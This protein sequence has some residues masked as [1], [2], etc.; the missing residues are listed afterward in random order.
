MHRHFTEIIWWR[1]MLAMVI[2]EGLSAAEQRLWDAFPTGRLVEFGTGTEEDADPARGK[3]WGPDRQ[4]RAEVLAALLC[5]AVEVELGQIGEVYLDGACIVGK[6]EL[7]GPAFKYDLRLRECYMGDGIDLSDATI[8][9][10]RLESCHIGAISLLRTKVSG[11]FSLR[12]AVVDGEDGMALNAAEL[13]VTG[14]VLCDDGFQAFGEINLA[15]AKIRGQFNLRGAVLDSRDGVA[16]NA[17]GLTVTGYVLCNEG[18]KAVGQVNLSGA[19]FGDFASFTGATFGDSASFDETAFGDSASF[20]GA[21]FGD[22]AS[23]D[24]TA[25][26][27][28]ASFTNAKFGDYASF[29]EARF[30]AGAS[31]G[32]ADFGAGAS[33]KETAFNG[34]ASFASAKFGGSASFTN[35]KFGDY[36]H[37]TNAKF[38]D[39]TAF[40]G[41][42]FGDY[43]AFSTVF[44]NNAYFDGAEFG[45]DTS[46]NETTFGDGASFNETT[47]GDRVRFVRTFFGDRTSFDETTFGNNVS[48]TGVNFGNDASFNETTFGDGASLY[49]TTLGDR[50]LFVRTFFGDRALFFETAFGKEAILGA[51]GSDL[52]TLTRLQMG[53]GSSIEATCSRLYM[54]AAAFPD[55]V[56]MLVRKADVWIHLSNFGGA[57]VIA[58][59]RPFEPIIPDFI[60]PR[61]PLPR[62]LSLEFCDVTH[63]TVNSLDLRACR[64]AGTY[65]LEQLRIGGATVF[66]PQPSARWWTRRLVLAEEHAWRAIYEPG[67]RSLG[68]YPNECREREEP[69]P[70]RRPRERRSPAARTEAETVEVTYR[71]LRKGLEDVKNEPGAADF[72]YGEMEMR[73]HAASPRSVERALLFLYWLVAGY[74]LRASRA[75]AALLLV[76]TLATV[77][78]VVVGFAPSVT[79]VYQ[80]VTVPSG[81]RYQ[82]REIRGAPPG[83]SE[84]ATYSVQSTTSLLRTPTN[85]P[86]TASGQVIDIVLRLLGPVLFGLAILAVRGRVKR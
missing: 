9:T 2:A 74:G 72:Y 26:G 23:F 57:S 85:E 61:L 76:L 67:R 35:A 17:A 75:L 12:G 11:A 50:V 14:P 3:G 62:L 69:A 1:M 78:F 52:I 4:V 41:A 25:F 13:N 83:W 19:K 46:F 54:S 6:L 70:G 30:G 73:R 39:Y 68:W 36:A 66:A 27:D 64:F 56:S 34:H 31:F 33:F 48:F 16:L 77:G 28:S 51:I 10:L 8:Q 29:N 37:F 40:I 60:G 65:N 59:L 21:T 63:V 42:E 38:G 18:F 5:G 20:T 86:L 15:G 49:K 58:V 81:I 84:A 43:A 53:R 22:S 79:T 7:S 47:L 80:Q 45:N 71:A 24:E 44:G 55:G 32:E 82:P